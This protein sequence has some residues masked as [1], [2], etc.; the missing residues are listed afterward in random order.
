MGL[1][2]S[3]VIVPIAAAALADRTRLV[4]V[5]VLK[6]LVIQM[7]HLLAKKLGGMLNR[8][9]FFMPISQSLKLDVLQARQ[10]LELYQEYIWVGGILLI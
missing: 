7:F 8:R 9:I 3:S 4:R 5:V 10:I 1:G 2:K 6:P